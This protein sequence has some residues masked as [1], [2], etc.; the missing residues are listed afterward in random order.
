MPHKVFSLC[1]VTM[2]RGPL[3]HIIRLCDES[4][5]SLKD[6]EECGKEEIYIKEVCEW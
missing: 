2:D 1:V 4:I 6:F 5:M 3:N